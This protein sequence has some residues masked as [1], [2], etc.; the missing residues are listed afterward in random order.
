VD[1]SGDLQYQIPRVLVAV[2]IA[3]GATREIYRGIGP[4]GASV[5]PLVWRRSPEIFAAY[6]T[7]PGGYSFGYTVIRPGQ[8][9][10]RTEPD[11]SVLGMAASRDG[12]LV[13]GTWLFE[14]GGVIKVWPVDDF[15]K[16]TELKLPA[17]ERIG[18]QYWWP[19]RNEVAFQAWRP[20]DGMSRD[21]RIE[22]WDPVSGARVVLARLADDVQPGAFL[23]RA[24]GSG[25]LTL[26]PY[27]PGAWEVRDLRTGTTMTIPQKPGENILRTVLLR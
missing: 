26:G 10:I 27:P 19:D 22:R 17:D 15:S 8:A 16:K 3:S 5:V 25:L 20:A 21:R 9:P 6:E 12:A 7:G 23:V 18:Q 14:S 1:D 24:D 11:T 13:S 4:S 2:D